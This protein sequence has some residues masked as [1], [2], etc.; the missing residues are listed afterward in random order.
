MSLRT[1]IE[2]LRARFQLAEGPSLLLGVAPS[3][4]V[5]DEVRGL[6]LGILGA[7]PLAVEDLGSCTSDRG[8]ARWAEATQAHPQAEGYVLSFSPSTPLEARAFAHGLNTEREL[9]RRLEGPVLLVV[10]HETENAIRKHAPDFF[11]WVAHSYELDEPRALLALATSV[12]VA[13]GERQAGLPPEEPVRFLHV[14]DLHLRPG[15]VKRYDQD[16]VLRGLLDLLEHDRPSFPLD[17]V[18]V[19]GDL[20]W[21]G[22]EGEYVSVVELLRALVDTTGVPPERMFVVPGN[23]DV[24]RS[25]GKWLLRTLGT[26]ADSIAFFEEASARSFHRRKLEA[27]ETGLRPLLGPTRSLGLEVGA[28]AVEMVEVRGTRLAIASFNSA[29]FSQGDSDQGQLWLGEP[30]V[31]R[32]L[33]RI[34]DEEAAFAIALLHHPFDYLHEIERDLVEHRFERGF[35]LVLRGHLHANKTRSIASQRGG[36]VEVAAPAAYQGSHWPNGCFLG[37]IRPKA[38]T[39]RLR[40]YEFAT[41]ADPWVLNAKV[42]PDDAADGYCRTFEIPVKRRRKSGMAAISLMAVQHAYE[43]ATPQQQREIQHSVLS[44]GRASDSRTDHEAVTKLLMEEPENALHDLLGKSFDVA[45]VNAI[46]RAASA[47][48]EPRTDVTDAAG[49]EQALVRAGRLFVTHVG[50]SGMKRSHLPESPAI[51]GFAAALGSVV[52]ARIG[53]ETRSGNFRLDLVIGPSHVPGAFDIIELTRVQSSTPR[54]RLRHKLKQMDHYLQSLQAR[55]VAVVLVGSLP[56]GATEP[57]IER[58]KTPS[59][60]DVFVLHL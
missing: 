13:L 56:E 2:E 27:Y 17:L 41:G 51:L 12:G 15:R 34:A 11:T 54:L 32:A 38:R 48:S 55:H 28:E 59:G 8:P 29:W 22:D 5:V 43:S 23:H 20:A 58:S 6:V 10:S 4:A 60:R 25:V 9:L 53:V 1:V 19:T 40:P 50:E 49:F 18:F 46:D 37:E 31:S 24:D 35:D 21:S 44:H 33:D 47:A 16:R 7:T 52:D 26:D 36:Y 45:V 14:S 3:N 30:G 42:F 39:V 57:R